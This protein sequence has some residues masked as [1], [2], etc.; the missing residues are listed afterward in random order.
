MTEPVR[1]EDHLPPAADEHGD[2]DA[3]NATLRA[4]EAM[5]LR[6]LGLSWEAIST[7]QG[8]SDR[9]GSR[10]LVERYAQALLAE[11]AEHM[12]ATWNETHRLQLSSAA[13]I[14]A[15]PNSAPLVKLRAN[16]TITRIA[17]SSAKL[18]GLDAPIRIEVGDAARAAV[19][20]ALS[21]LEDT[22]LGEVT[23]VTDEPIEDD[24]ERQAL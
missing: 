12:R 13:A 21:L 19:E 14:M 7:R 10:K 8:Y 9:N 4:A 24:D 20:Q 5:R 1:P 6:G 11:Q 2:P 3:I 18:N 16:D 15:D 23:D 17:R 22:V